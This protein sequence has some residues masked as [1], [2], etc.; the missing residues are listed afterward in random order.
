[1]PKKMLRT[2]VMAV[3]MI[4]I[5]QLLRA[6]DFD[7]EVPLPVF[8]GAE[9]F[10]TH[11]T[12]GR[13]GSVCRVTSLEDSGK[14]TL[15][16]CVNRPGK[17]I[18]V[19][20]TGGVITLKSTLLLNKPFISILG[21]TAPGDGIMIR[22]SLDFG[23][24]AV[25]IKTHDVLLQHLRIRVGT[26]TEP[27]CC[28]DALSIANNTP[29]QV[30]NVVVDHSSIS[31][32]TDE[33]ADIWYDSNNITISRNIISEGLNNSTNKNGI[34]GRGFIIGS[35]GS[36]S[37]SFHHNFLAHN[38]Q[39]NPLVKSPGVTDVVSNLVYHWVSRAAGVQGEYGDTRV[40]FVNNKFIAVRMRDRHQRSDRR[41]S[42]IS[43]EDFGNKLSIYLEANE[44]YRL[45]DPDQPQ[46]DLIGVGKRAY[47]EKY[48]YVAETRHAAPAITET[49][50]SELEIELIK[51]VGATLPRQDAVDLRL[52][53]ELESG[54]GKMPDCV[55]ATDPP[56]KRVCERNNVGGWPEYDP[57]TPREDTDSDG[58]PDDWE[59][60]N[61]TDPLNSAD[62]VEIDS[63]GYANIEI[64]A[65]SLAQ[66]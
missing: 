42:D 36:H 33:V 15:R 54:T 23:G 59:I 25:Q 39:R 6:A 17:K 26:S 5:P 18:V 64:F 56:S 55:V 9:G 41:W 61:G 37:I 29:G 63:S 66:N 35:D 12:G 28:R 51:N 52:F 47:K 58:L 8:P 40:N 11:T 4:S 62:S 49:P 48:D 13:H 27:S 57:G 16:S 43:V 2:F 31:W 3:L 44:G 19:F 24:P 30:Y 34:A 60:A 46:S 7:S 22:G 21:Q 10:G 45:E 20:A 32:G 53:S 38:Y 1:M 14:G 50:S 65:H